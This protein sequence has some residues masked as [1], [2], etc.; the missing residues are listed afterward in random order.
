M[1]YLWNIYD[2]LDETESCI[3]VSD[4]DGL[5]QRVRISENTPNLKV[6]DG[7]S[8]GERKERKRPVVG[9]R[10]KYLASLGVFNWRR[11]AKRRND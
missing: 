5:V 7:V 10:G 2:F 4:D 6:Y 9:L 1:V 8:A 11:T 3:E